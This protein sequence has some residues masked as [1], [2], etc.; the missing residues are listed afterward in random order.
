MKAVAVWLAV[1]VIAWIMYS[2]PPVEPHYASSEHVA[3][4]RAFLNGGR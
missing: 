1:I 2:A 3:R 4:D